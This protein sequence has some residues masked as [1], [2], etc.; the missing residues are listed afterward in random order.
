VRPF[1][2][3]RVIALLVTGGSIPTVNAHPHLFIDVMAKFM[4]ADSVLSGVNIFWDLD[5]MTSAPLIEEF[6]LN[7][8]STFEKTEYDKIYQDVFSWASNSNYFMVVTWGKKMLQISRTERFV[9]TILPDKK[10]RYSFF[11][12][13][14]IK[15]PDI[16]NEKFVM[17]FNDPSMFVAF[18]LNRKMIT[19]AENSGWKGTVSFEKEDYNDLIILSV[20]RKSQ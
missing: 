11:V 18:D 2:L 8:N 9:A 17:F 5:E 6:D 1:L 4:F 10:I 12:P 20:S 15:L 3:C 7:G 14:D 19:P 13:F 16:V